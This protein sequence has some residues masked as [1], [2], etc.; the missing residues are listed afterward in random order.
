MMPNPLVPTVVAQHDR[1]SAALCQLEEDYELLEAAHAAV[2]ARWAQTA[3]A[4]WGVTREDLDECLTLLAAERE[5]LLEGE[6]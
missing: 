6:R 2:K 5:A 3:V 1:C 4:T